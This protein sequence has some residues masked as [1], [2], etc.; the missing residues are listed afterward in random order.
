M[1]PDRWVLAIDFGT[2]NTAAAQMGATEDTIAP[3]ALTHGSNLL[4]SAVTVRSIDDILTGEAALNAAHASP[5]GFVS[6]PKRLIALP[7]LRIGHVE[8][9][10]SWVVAAVLRSVQ[11]KAVARHNGVPPAHV[12]L[13]HPEAWPRHYVATLVDAAAQAG[14]PPH[15]VTTVSEP[16]AAAHHYTRGTRLAPGTTIA[17]F[18][19]GG[20]TADVAVLRAT[21]TGT[22]EVVAAR[23][24]NGLGGKNFDAL[25]RRWALSRLAETHPDLHAEFD[26]NAPGSADAIRALDESARTAKE[27]L[28]DSPS[29]TITVAGRSARTTLVLT[30]DEFDALITPQ[31]ETAVALVRD[32]LG[33]AGIAPGSLHAVYLTGGSSRVPL[34]HRALS[35]LGPIATLD[36]PKTVVSQGALV[37]ARHAGDATAAPSN[38]TRSRSGVRPPV[39]AAA[40]VAT[41]LLAGAVAWFALGDDETPAATAA[42][43]TSTTA[44]PTT[45]STVA[46]APSTT[47]AATTTSVSTPVVAT[48]EARVSTVSGTDRQGFVDTLGPRCN[49]TNEAVAVGRTPE[50]RI[51]VCRTGVD[52][53]YYKGLR[54]EDGSAIE[55]DDPTQ[56]P[57]GYVVANEGVTYEFDQDLLIISG[58]Y[59]VRE[60]MLEFWAAHI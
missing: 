57:G 35:S 11:A 52:R 21:D 41:V 16:R 60:P 7:V 47:P 48:S 3:V 26:E 9:P 4:P 19:F 39:L 34:V 44:A 6:A 50:S 25:V 28:S 15:T 5:E 20:G 17:V 2:S 22:F 14:I 30:R 43:A 54:V 53:L 13:T 8:L 29:A 36:D 42:P 38:P 31:I 45:T 46:T 37:A 1:G 24:D 12:V 59:L 51:V 10:V 49:S 18:D 55:I 33:D 40:A 32:A 56:T 23:G 58:T 27:V